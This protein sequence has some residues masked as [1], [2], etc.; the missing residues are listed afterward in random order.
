MNHEFTTRVSGIPCICRVNHYARAMP[1]RFSG[2]PEDCYP[3]EPSEFE[4]TILDSRGRPAAWLEKKLTDI[5]RERL[6]E[7]W[8]ATISEH[9]N[10]VNERDD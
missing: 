7:E 5:D 2:P 3:S 1:G 9:N 8:E 10:Y 6:E 4:F